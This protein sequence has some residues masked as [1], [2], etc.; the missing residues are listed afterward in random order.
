VRSVRSARSTHCVLHA[1]THA[2]GAEV[3]PTGEAAARGERW[4]VLACS[5]LLS[6]P[7]PL[8]APDSC[9]AGG[10]GPLW[11]RLWRCANWMRCDP[12]HQSLKP[13]QPHARTMH[14]GLEGWR[15]S[16]RARA[17]SINAAHHSPYVSPCSYR[18]RWRDYVRRTCHVVLCT[19]YSTHACCRA[20]SSLFGVSKFSVQV[21]RS[22]Q[23]ISVFSRQR[24]G[25]A[26]A[27]S[28]RHWS[29]S[30]Q[31]ARSAQRAGQVQRAFSVE[32]ESRA[33]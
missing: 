3:R 15:T 26:R 10:H 11:T 31:Q 6:N 18:C 20:H 25:S 32:S 16:G 9:H 27:A 2:A 14:G 33:A 12:P 23:F 8:R 1:V 4:E 24:G 22:S 30:T 28:D 7:L 29:A 21:Q 5:L 13:P 17:R 19:L